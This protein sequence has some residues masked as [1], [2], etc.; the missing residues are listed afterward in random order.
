MSIYGE[1]LY[2]DADGVLHE[3]VLRG[4]RNR[5]GSW[6]P[7]D[8]AGPAP[9]ACAD[10]RDQATGPR[11]VYAIN[12]YV[13]ERLTLTLRRPTA[14]RAWPCGCGMP[15]GRA[16]PSP[17]PIPACW[18]SSPRA[19]PTGSGRW[20]SRTASSAATSSMSATWPAPS[21]SR[22]SGPSAGTGLQ[23]R[24]GEDRTC[25][26]RRAPGRAMGRPDLA[27]RDHRQGPQRRHPPQHPRHRPR[28]RRPRL[29]P[30]QDFHQGLEE[31]AEWVARNSKPRTT[32]R[33]R[34]TSS[35]LRGLVA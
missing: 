34:G 32:W 11:L 3:D 9:E 29:H 21:C 10:A 15:T 30:R 19:S 4:P 22:W 35:K 7:L 1:G 31:L 17:I 24:S 8:A 16:R 33:R 27:P 5:D 26:G 2:R 23:R 18:R 12:K 28:P 20:S 6:D 14:W 25:R 13:Q